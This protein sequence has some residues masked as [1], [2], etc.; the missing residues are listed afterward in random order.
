MG[1]MVQ[2][3]LPDGRS[4]ATTTAPNVG[5]ADDGL[6]DLFRQRAMAQLQPRAQAQAQ[7]KPAAIGRPAMRRNDPVNSMSVR[8]PQKDPYEEVVRRE[9]ATAAIAQARAISG[10]A[11]MKNTTFA[12]S[13]SGFMMDPN[14]MTGAQRQA[15]LPGS[16]GMAPPSAAG[17]G[18]SG[19]GLAAGRFQEEQDLELEGKRRALAA[20]TGR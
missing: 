19:G 10:G 6:M 16:A 7:Q 11:P 13:P 2:R 8:A 15:F 9:Q 4:I 12:N 5:G 17:L 20:M 18:Q 1:S 14:Q 3:Y